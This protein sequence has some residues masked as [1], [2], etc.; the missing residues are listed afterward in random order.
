MLLSFY[1]GRSQSPWLSA[2]KGYYFQFS[3]NTIP[4]YNSLFNGKNDAF[5]TSR[6]I[7]DKTLQLYGEYG[8]SQDFSIIASIPIKFLNSG[9]LNPNYGPAVYSILPAASVNALGNMQFSI[10][11][12]LLDKKWVAALQFSIEL[13]AMV[14]SGLESGLLPGYDAFSF[15]PILSIGRGWNKFYAYYWLSSIF[16]ANNYSDYLNTGI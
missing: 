4:E 7:Q 14:S 13:P 3:Y 11:Y 16:R 10:K 9:E 2:E 12:K 6:Y 8:I 1:T 5:Q 15:K